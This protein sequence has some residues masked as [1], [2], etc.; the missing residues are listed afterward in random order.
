MEA[1]GYDITVCVAAVVDGGAMAC[2]DE[3]YQPTTLGQ[4]ECPATELEDNSAEI[5]CYQSESVREA[6]EMF[7]VIGTSSSSIPTPVAAPTP[8]PSSGAV[9]APTPDA[10]PTTVVAPSLDPTPAPAKGI[11]RLRT[12]VSKEG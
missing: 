5:E 4:F 9:V 11:K 10:S 6:A 7:T 1:I 3:V 8:D 2:A 12:I